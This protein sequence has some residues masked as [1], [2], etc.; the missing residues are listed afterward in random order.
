MFGMQV[1]VGKGGEDAFFV[2]EALWGAIGVA[3][4]V[5]GWNEDGVDSAL[6]SR[7]PPYIPICT[8]QR[9]PRSSRPE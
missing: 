1:A 4:G 9:G 5:G 6:F 3:D 2:S 7:F 8:S